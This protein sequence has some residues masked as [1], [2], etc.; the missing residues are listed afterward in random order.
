MFHRHLGAEDRLFR[1]GGVGA[2]FGDRLQR[3]QGIGAAVVAGHG[4]VAAHLAIAVVIGGFGQNHHRRAGEMRL[5]DAEAAH[6]GDPGTLTH[7]DRRLAREPARSL[8]HDRGDPFVAAQHHIE[9]VLGIVEGRQGPGDPQPRQ[10]KGPF[11]AAFDQRAY[12]HF[13]RL[14]HDLSVSS[15]IGPAARRAVAGHLSPRRQ[16]Y[17]FRNWL[18]NIF[19]IVF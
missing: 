7:Q 12:H 14:R 8:C 4:L 17:R 16:G 18:A 11:N 9:I 13:I 19:E 3:G 5:Q 2:V 10:G 15:R 6:G 1:R